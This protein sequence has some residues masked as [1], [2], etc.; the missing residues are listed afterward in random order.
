[1]THFFGVCLHYHEER[2]E[3]VLASYVMSEQN[4]YLFVLAKH[5]ICIMCPSLGHCLSCQFS[6]C[7]KCKL[8]HLVVLLCAST[9]HQKLVQSIL[10][11][12]VVAAIKASQ[13]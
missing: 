1:M 9:D 2:S 8:L 3:A 7:W 5:L 11:T 6:A 10:M 13:I 12:A 4:V